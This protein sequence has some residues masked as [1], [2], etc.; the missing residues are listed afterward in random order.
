[1]VLSLPCPSLATR[2]GHNWEAMHMNPRLC[3]PSQHGALPIASRLQPVRN[4]WTDLSSFPQKITECIDICLGRMHCLSQL[5]GA[6]KSLMFCKHPI[7]HPPKMQHYG[8][9][10]CFLVR[11]CCFISDFN[12]SCCVCSRPTVRTVWGV[13]PPWE[14]DSKLSL[15][16]RTHRPFPSQIRVIC[17][18]HCSHHPCIP[19]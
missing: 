16:F 6:G 17:R 8:G 19:I 14:K 13:L 9:G 10:G 5:R 1:M 7:L 11:F 4:I 18:T 12:D 3:N 15:S 2:Q